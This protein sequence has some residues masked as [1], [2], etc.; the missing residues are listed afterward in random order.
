M[1]KLLRNT[2]AQDLI[3][4]ALAAGLVAVTLGAFM[5]DVASNLS[6]IFSEL[7][8]VPSVASTQR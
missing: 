7:G 2:I 1:K 8:A 4:Y 3:E 5:P 6:A